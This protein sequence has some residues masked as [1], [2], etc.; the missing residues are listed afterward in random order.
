VDQICPRFL[1]LLFK[2]GDVILFGWL[3]CLLVNG[4]R[5]GGLLE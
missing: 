2:V 1:K 3:A 4:S 5:C